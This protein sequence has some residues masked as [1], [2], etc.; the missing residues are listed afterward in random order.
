MAA[1]QKSKIYAE[2]QVIFRNIMRTDMLKNT[3]DQ[4]LLF[5]FQKK[6]GHQDKATFH[7]NKNYF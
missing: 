1:G 6:N 7:Q 4:V 2:P 3:S 5:L